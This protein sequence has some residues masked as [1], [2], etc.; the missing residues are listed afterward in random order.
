MKLK[1]LFS[2]AFFGLLEVVARYLVMCGGRGSGKSE[3]A[4][5]KLLARGWKE[6]GHRFLV[7]RKVRK[8]L[9]D[10]VIRV[11]LTK[12][13]ENQIP[14]D[15]NKSDRTIMVKGPR[16]VFWFLFEGLDDPEKLKSIKGI[17]SIWIEEA[18]EFSR[19]DFL[20]VDLCLREPGPSYKQIM[21]TFNPQEAEA[22]W[23]KEMF[24]GPSPYPDS[25]VHRSTVEDNPVPEVREG[26]IKVLDQLKGQ[27]EALYQIARLGVWAVRSGQIFGWDVVPWPVDEA[28]RPRPVAWFDDVWYGGDYGYSV[29]PSAVVRIYRKAWEF[30]LEQVIYRV[31]LTN[32]DLGELMRER[33]VGQEPVYFDSAEPKSNEELRRM[34]FR[35]RPAEK[36]PDSV[37]AGIDFIKG[38]CKVH[39]LQGNPDLFREVSG[40][41]WRKD[42]SGQSVGEP[43]QD[44][45]HAID[46]VRYGIFSHCAK[47]RARIWSA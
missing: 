36:G 18:T 2:D 25:H 42:R 9:A 20:K 5:N 47:A 44:E 38:R 34:G 33:G 8:T 45:N 37:R 32:Q 26:Y 43:V 35:V 1:L 14:Y 16:G 3:A 46:A 13:E 30:W 10:S 23:L 40:Y 24:F 22:R 29:D 15:Y 28:G 7:M 27:D 6:G 41:C 17:T 21:L 31:G 19:D 39:I 12:L 11:I 4:A